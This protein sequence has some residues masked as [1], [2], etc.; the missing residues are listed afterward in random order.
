M[1]LLLHIFFY[2]NHVKTHTN[3]SKFSAQKSVDYKTQE[4]FFL[5]NSAA[6]KRKR[7]E[8]NW[9]VC[10]VW[11]S[12]VLLLAIPIMHTHESKIKISER[13]ISF[14]RERRE[15]KKN[16]FL[17]R[18]NISLFVLQSTV[19]IVWRLRNEYRTKNLAIFRD[20]SVDST[21]GNV[22]WFSFDV[23]LLLYIRKNWDFVDDNPTFFI[24]IISSG[25]L[26]AL[27]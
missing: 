15:E 23:K 12:E 27:G 2:Q 20:L 4:C 14:K 9:S 22:F 26:S 3:R 19:G 21:Y 24:E 16:S 25:I 1:L 11:R 13:K 6:R 5:T 18:T 17:E 8:R 7:F 10:K